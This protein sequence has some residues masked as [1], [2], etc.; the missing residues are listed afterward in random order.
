MSDYQDTVRSSLSKL[1]NEEL[2]ARI[3]EGG[4]TDEASEI[5]LSILRDRGHSFNGEINSDGGSVSAIT[6]EP[7][8]GKA[9][10]NSLI[11]IWLVAL[12]AFGMSQHVADSFSKSS[13]AV[14][15]LKF[16]MGLFYLFIGGAIAIYL[17]KKKNKRHNFEQLALRYKSRWKTLLILLGLF[18]AFALFRIF[19]TNFSIGI[20]ADL[21]I[22]AGL[23]VAL[24]LRKHWAYVGIAIYA[25]FNSVALGFMGIGGASGILWTFV[26]YY[27][28]CAA[29]E[30]KHLTL[31]E[32]NE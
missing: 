28:A 30:R 11:L 10:N 16:A 5:A 27:A 20:F 18:V 23:G 15:A 25:L 31:L 22:T 7:L 21:A 2:L 17:I 8:T 24:Y 29:L 6:S 26:F 3:N 9:F 14:A 4:L 12:F 13:A 19:S 32:S 1:E